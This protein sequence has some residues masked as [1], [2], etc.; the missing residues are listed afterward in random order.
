MYIGVVC[1]PRIKTRAA[2]AVATVYVILGVL[3]IGQIF[4]AINWNALMIIA[5]TML[6]V[7]YFMASH[8][9]LPLL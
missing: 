1:F 9:H 6:I 4:E 3:P 2:L 8:S 7:Y 5:G